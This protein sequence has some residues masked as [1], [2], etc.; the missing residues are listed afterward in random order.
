M[1][2][3]L[4]GKNKQLSEVDDPSADAI[5]SLYE[6]QTELWARVRPAHITLEKVWLDVLIA[7]LTPGSR[8][9][10]VGCG[11]GVPI[12]EYFIRQQLQVTGVDSAPSMI[13]Q[14]QKRFPGNQW[15]CTDM[16]SLAL[17]QQFSAIVAWD[18]FFHLT[19]HA[20]RQMFPRFAKHALP[21]ASLLFNSGP[22]NGEAIGRFANQDLYHASLSADE[23]RHL[24]H[25]SGFEVSHHVVEDAASGGRTV[26]LA[27]KKT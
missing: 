18:S 24:L 17:G 16:R 8:I 5:I 25:Q 21:G 4:V 14:C 19:R 13:A 7:N 26:W 12:A 9:L 2:N 23:Y 27:H 15:H 10:D 22:E 11:N 6:A 3:P 1:P 20:Q